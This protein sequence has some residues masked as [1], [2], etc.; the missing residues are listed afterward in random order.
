MLIIEDETLIAMIIQDLLEEGG[1]T[2]VDFAV[3]QD[4]AVSAAIAHRPAFMTSD[5]KLLEGTGPLAVAEIHRLLGPVPV[6]FITATP[7]D[8][9]PCDPSERIFR[10][11]INR[12]EIIRVFHEMTLD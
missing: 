6:I 7:E 3:T 2:S 1:A 12:D 11:P 8:C 4:E 10:K 9:R 5:V